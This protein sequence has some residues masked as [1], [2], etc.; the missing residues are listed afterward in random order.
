[1]NA[2]RYFQIRYTVYREYG[3][4][5]IS[6]FILAF[7]PLYWYLTIAILGLTLGIL[8]PGVTP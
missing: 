6:A 8:L 3:H 1:M 4:A 5:P 7:P 2:F